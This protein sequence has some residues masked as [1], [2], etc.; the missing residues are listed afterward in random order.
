MTDMNW[1]DYIVSDQV[2]ESAIGD[3]I[4]FLDLESGTYLGVDGVGSLIWKAIKDGR[5]KADICSEIV[6]SFDVEA[7]RAA[8]DLE[9]FVSDLVARGLL[10]PRSDQVEV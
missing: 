3:E 4:V 10:R 1:T 6:A 2:V 7:A 9:Q 5:T 8:E